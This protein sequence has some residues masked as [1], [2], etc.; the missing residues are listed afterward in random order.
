MHLGEVLASGD[1]ASVRA[2]PQVQEIYL[3]VPIEA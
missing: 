1:P 2:N 3:G